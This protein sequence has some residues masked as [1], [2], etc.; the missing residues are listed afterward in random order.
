M[1]TLQKREPRNSDDTSVT[2]SLAGRVT[3]SSVAKSKRLA[4]RKKIVA[5]V[6]KSA[7]W[8]IGSA[9]L[10]TFEVVLTSILI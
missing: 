5:T 2:E 4:R 8:L 9:V 3:R 10:A 1:S 6:G 7:V